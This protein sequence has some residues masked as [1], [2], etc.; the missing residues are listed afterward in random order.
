MGA[1]SA[2]PRDEVNALA[3]WTFWTFAWGAGV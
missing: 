2:S 1:V 3:Q